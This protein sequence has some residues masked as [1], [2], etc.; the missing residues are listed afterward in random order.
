MLTIEPL[1]LAC[2][3]QAIKIAEYLIYSLGDSLSY[4]GQTKLSPQ[5]ILDKGVCIGKISQSFANELTSPRITYQKFPSE[6]SLKQEECCICLDSLCGNEITILEC[7]H[8]FHA[9]C[10]QKKK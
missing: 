4:R 6:D 9:S 8:A 5:D 10:L 1:H 7:G 3:Y 2:L